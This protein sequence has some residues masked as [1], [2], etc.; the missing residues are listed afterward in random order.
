MNNYRFT[1]YATPSATWTFDSKENVVTLF[2][3]ENGKKI[4]YKPTAKHFVEHR[5]RILARGNTYGIK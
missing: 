2:W 1:S 5:N 3:K 4:K